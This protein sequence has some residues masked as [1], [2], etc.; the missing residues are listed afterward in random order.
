MKRRLQ[1]WGGIHPQSKGVEVGEDMI[2]RSVRQRVK[3]RSPIE[4]MMIE[5]RD[6]AGTGLGCRAL[7]F[8][9]VLYEYISLSEWV[10]GYCGRRQQAVGTRMVQKQSGRGHFSITTSSSSPSFP[11][12]ERMQKREPFSRRLPR[13]GR[14]QSSDGAHSSSMSRPAT[15]SQLLKHQ[16]TLAKRHTRKYSQKDLPAH[17]AGHGQTQINCPTGKERQKE[18][19]RY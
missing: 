11:V 7:D 2:K 4:L 18:R 5:I 19:K 13:S 14:P 17:D 9:H 8:S 10:G 1:K 12:N 3:C 15:G 6:F 16:D